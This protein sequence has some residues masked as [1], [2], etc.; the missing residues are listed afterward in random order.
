MLTD[1]ILYCLA[2]CDH[3]SKQL[4]S[5]N[6]TPEFEPQHHS[7]IILQCLVWI[8]GQQHLIVYYV[9]HEIRTT[10]K[11]DAKKVGT[12]Y[13]GSEVVKNHLEDICLPLDTLSKII[14]ICKTYYHT[15][16]IA[17]FT[18]ISD[19]IVILCPLYKSTI[20][21]ALYASVV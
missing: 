11:H 18:Q 20:S 13:L 7:Y 9:C 21:G 10:N 6:I 4:I 19:L 2:P 8:K 1:Q 3:L 17:K 16:I 12:L 14:Q 5:Y 15:K